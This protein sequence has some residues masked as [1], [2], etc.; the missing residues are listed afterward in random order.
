MRL[1]VI[2]VNDRVVLIVKTK[3]KCIKYIN[4]TRQMNGKI[5]RIFVPRTLVLI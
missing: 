4:I 5:K 1:I 3:I 2:H